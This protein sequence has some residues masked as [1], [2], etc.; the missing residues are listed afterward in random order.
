MALP[1]GV[2][3]HR[4]LPPG[5][6][7]HRVLLWKHRRHRLMRTAPSQKTQLA[8]GGPS[9]PG[10]LSVGPLP[11][12]QPHRKKMRRSPSR[13]GMSSLGVP[14]MFAGRQVSPWLLRVMSCWYGL[15]ASLARRQ[16]PRLRCL[17]GKMPAT[18]KQ[19]NMHIKCGKSCGCWELC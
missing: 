14:A 16:N 13:R 3:H 9:P 6:T 8:P 5:V 12:M 15:E 7:H 2:T 10:L 17:Q 19:Y 4:V 1:Q 11:W 18:M